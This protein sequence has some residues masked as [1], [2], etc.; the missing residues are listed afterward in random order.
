MKPAPKEGALDDEAGLKFIAHVKNE[1]PTLPMLLLSTDSVNRE[2]ANVIQANFQD[3]TLPP[4]IWKFADSWLR[5][6]DLEILFSVYRMELN[7]PVRVIFFHSRK[8]SIIC[9]EWIPS[10][11]HVSKN[12]FS[13]WLTAR[14]EITLASK[15]G[16]V[17]PQDFNN[18]IEAIRTFLIESLRERRIAEQRG[19]ITLFNPED[20][21]S[22]CEFMRLGDGF[23][24]ESLS[25]FHE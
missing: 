12:H 3:K 7:V 13:N 2:K 23:L 15:F 9:T 20:F 24:E 21:D 17:T 18:D 10:N 19:V 25:C 4:F 6:W 5:I 22:E 16:P 1:L 14:S 11:Y 8:F